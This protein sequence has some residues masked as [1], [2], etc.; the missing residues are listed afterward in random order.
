MSSAEGDPAAPRAA[1]FEIPRLRTPRLELR[2]FADADLNAYA[3]ICADEEVMR[4]IGAGGPVG[5]DVAWR[6]MA[7][8]NGS[9]S[10]RGL[11]M[12]AIEE[13][14]S[15]ALIG[16]VGYLCPPDWPGIELGWLLAREHWGRGHAVEAARAARAFGR[17]HL[18]VADLISLI[19]PDNTRSIVLAERLGARLDGALTLMGQQAL[20][21]RHPAG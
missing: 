20:V 6:Q 4:H 16:R 17:A 21:Y 3:H 19:R 14:S 8:F 9:W 12:W 11:G 13:R 1:V 10:L 18:G 5:A 15:G 2:A 7:I